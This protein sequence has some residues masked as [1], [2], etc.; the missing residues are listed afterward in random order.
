MGNYAA[1]ITACRRVLARDEVRENAYQA[2]MRYQAESGDSAAAL[3]TYERCR[4][5]LAEELGADPSPL[6]QN[7]HQR[8][9][10]GEVEP[11]ATERITPSVVRTTP[12]APSINQT[13]GVQAT[14]PLPQQ[15][16]LP[17][18]DEHFIN[19]FVGREQEQEQLS[20]RLEQ[21]LAGKGQLILL[22]GEAGVGKARLAYH[23]LQEA[24]RWRDRHQRHLSS[25][26]TAVALCRPGRRDWALSQRVAG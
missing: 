5:I 22:E 15:T 8:I 4:T 11:R 19:V 24:R 7:W 26:R 25:A 13:D 23:G 1:A 17:M 6:T 21:A 9:L 16:L 2:L 18:L 10:N 20:E 12:P 3:L 14:L